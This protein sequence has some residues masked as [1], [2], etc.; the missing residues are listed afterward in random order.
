[1]GK[2]R[3]PQLHDEAWLKYQLEDEGKSYSQIAKEIGSTRAPVM[4]AAKKF[5][6]KSVHPSRA[7]FKHGLGGT[8]LPKH[9]DISFYEK[10]AK[11]YLKKARAMLEAGEIVDPHC[12]KGEGES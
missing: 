8:S 10:H 9:N 4:A 2:I 5:G 12:D 6:L 11:C 1:M 7:P 3:Y